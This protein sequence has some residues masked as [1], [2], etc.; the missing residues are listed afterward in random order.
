MSKRKSDD[1]Q[2]QEGVDD[3]CL[4]W[5][6]R[7][8]DCDASRD[9]VRQKIRA[10]IDSGEMTESEFRTT[11]NITPEI[12]SRFMSEQ[13]EFKGAG[14]MMYREAW[15]FLKKRELR[16][17]QTTGKKA[18][19]EMQKAKRR[20]VRNSGG[21]SLDLSGVVLDGEMEDKVRVYDT[22]DMIRDKIA[23]H[24]EKENVTQAQF[25]R[26]DFMP[27]NGADAGNTNV[28]Y[29]GAYVLFEKMRIKN[30]EP[31]SDMRFQMEKIYGKTG[32]VDI[33]KGSYRTYFT[34]LLDDIPVQDQYG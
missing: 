33:K 19:K 28:V 27:Y 18:D 29:Y 23:A 21:L 25:L 5:E 3:Q 30:G 20:A 31:K 17:Q 7:N 2:A 15:Q 4:D 1:F 26:D 6:V 11:I 8:M 10:L 12:Y 13:G 32:G 24:L 14:N 9:E 16:A 34:M 22:C